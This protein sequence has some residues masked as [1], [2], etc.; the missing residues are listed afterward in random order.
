MH[1]KKGMFFPIIRMKVHIRLSDGHF[2]EYFKTVVQVHIL[3]NQVK[4]VALPGVEL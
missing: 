1:I 4:G 2:R 3:I